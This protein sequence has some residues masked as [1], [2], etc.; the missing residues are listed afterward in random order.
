[1]GNLTYVSP[2]LVS[3]SDPSFSKLTAAD[4]QSQAILA[5]LSSQKPITRVA[6]EERQPI[7]DLYRNA[8]FKPLWLTGN[9]PLNAPRPFWPLPPRVSEDGMEPLA[10][11]PTGLSSFNNVDEQVGIDPQALAQFDI[12]MTAATLKLARRNFRRPV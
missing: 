5:E 1:M 10:Y 3:L 8:G 9:A 2:K 11:L 12:A 6:K 4:A 7:L